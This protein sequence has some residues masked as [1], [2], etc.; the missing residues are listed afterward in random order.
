MYFIV[1]SESE[2]VILLHYMTRKIAVE[3]IFEITYG[4][5]LAVQ[6][7]RL[8]FSLQGTRVWSLVGELGKRKKEIT[9]IP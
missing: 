2:K 3:L 1:G 8:V 7:L 9:C 4:I 6:W 5:S